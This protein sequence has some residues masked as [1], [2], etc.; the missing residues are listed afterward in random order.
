M[1]YRPEIDGLRAIAVIPVIFFHAGVSVFGG[2]FVGVDVFFVI[3]GYL[4]TKIILSEMEQGTFSLINFYE[5]RARR[6]LPALFLVMLVSHVFAWLWLVPGDMKDFS[7]SL[8]AVSTFSSNILFWCKSGYWDAASELKPLLHTWSLAVE[9]QYYI[10]FPLFLLLVWR[11]GKRWI[12]GSFM[13]VVGISLATAQWGAYHHPTATFYLLPTRGWELAIGACIAFYVLQRKDTFSKLLSHKTVKEVVGALGLLMIGYAVFT[14]NESIPFPSVYT[15]LPTIGTGLI[16]VFSS[17]QTI[18]GRLLS[19]KPLVA[20]GLISYSAYLW[21]QPLLVFARHRSLAEPSELTFVILAFLS[22]PFAYLSWR[23]VEKPF[24]TKGV[25][26]RKMIFSYSIIGSVAF[27]VIGLVGHFTNGFDSRASSSGFTADAIEYK[28]NANF[29][30]SETCEGKFTL[31]PD[32]RTDDRPEILVWGDSYAMHLVEGIMASKPDAKIIQ[33]TKSVC[34]PLFD[35]AP[36]IEPQY[37]VNWGKDCLEFTAKVRTW[38][39]DNDT[40]KYAVLSSPFGQ[41]LS[42]KHK[43]LSRSGDVFVADTEFVIK[44][45]RKTL[46]ELQE[47][48]ISPIVFSPPPVNGSDLGRCLAKAEWRGMTLDN[49]DFKVSEISQDSLLVF[50][51]LKTVEKTHSV[52]FLS[53]LICKTSHCMTHVDDIFIFRDSGHFSQEGSAAVGEKYDFYRMIIE[54]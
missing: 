27:F 3:S 35:V 26:S 12:L 28:L 45:L 46:E 34:G 37:S 25:F 33:M 9:E 49:C 54:N 15:L 20:L 10:L 16:I 40:I 19:T 36:I 8:I 5:R 7:Q 29:G 21:H 52:L 18:V 41:Y 50:E 30:L 47:L 48:G 39:K 32:C 6:I 44:E 43:L 53:D 1:K 31:S 24:R 4:I 13:L 17:S 2:G 51:F 42:T 22:I 14:F 23:Y 11:I 38:L